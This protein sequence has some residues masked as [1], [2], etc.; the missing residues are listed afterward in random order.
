[1]LGI[2]LQSD[3]LIDQPLEEKLSI[4]NLLIKGGWI[5][6]PLFLLFV[7]AIYIFLERYFSIKKGS[8]EN[9]TVMNKIKDYIKEGDLDL[10]LDLCQRTN[11]PITRL[12]EKGLTRIGNPLKEIHASVE[13]V[14]SL[15]IYKLE[16]NLATLATIS[17]AAP[18]IGFLGTVTG[19]IR[20]FYNLAQAGNNIDPG[21]L[22]GGI[23]E[24]MVTT[25]FGLAVGIIAYVGYNYL[26]SMV[27]KLV[28][29]M[30]ATSVEFI[31]LLQEPAQTE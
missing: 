31:D 6:I 28:Y 25:A 1:M 15:E 22:A 29:R 8:A 23:Y 20:A 10:A 5:M 7:L 16:K 19:M 17:G 9:P 24:A 27:E 30:E 11:T 13:N 26:T 18:M 21:Q 12:V 2:F 14:G 3:G 4:L